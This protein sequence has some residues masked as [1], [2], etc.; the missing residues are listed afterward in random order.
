MAV[1]PR[2]I[3]NL[4][5]ILGSLALI[6]GLLLR[7]LPGSF[8]WLGHLPGNFQVEVGRRGR[9]YI[10]LGTSLVLSLLLSLLFSILPRLLR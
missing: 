3:G 7:F 4:F 10:P 5:L 1:G 8:A 9:L 2:S 6:T